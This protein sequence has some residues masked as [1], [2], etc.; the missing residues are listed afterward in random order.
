MY[1]YLMSLIDCCMIEIESHAVISLIYFVG[2]GFLLVDGCHVKN[3]VAYRL[4]LWI[5]EWIHNGPQKSLI[6]IFILTDCTRCA[7]RSHS[8]MLQRQHTGYYFP[9]LSCHVNNSRPRLHRTGATRSDNII[10]GLAGPE[11]YWYAADVHCRVFYEQPKPGLQ[12]DEGLLAQAR[13]FLSRVDRVL[14]QTTN[15]GLAREG[16]GRWESALTWRSSLLWS[17]WLYCTCLQKST[18]SFG[19]QFVRTCFPHHLFA[20]SP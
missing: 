11:D 13:G 19:S 3:C 5:W 6:L 20:S 4:Y 10:I 17:T 8:S 1:I 7:A 2:A 15:D 16:A 14:A 18:T 9:C 12:P